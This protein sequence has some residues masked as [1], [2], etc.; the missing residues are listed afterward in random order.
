MGGVGQRLV[1]SRA[2]ARRHGMAHRRNAAWP[3]RE[4]EADISAVGKRRYVEKPA[5]W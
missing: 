2:E 3:V 1:A 5:A 4:I